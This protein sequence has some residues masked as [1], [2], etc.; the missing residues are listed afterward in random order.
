MPCCVHFLALQLTCCGVVC[1]AHKNN[2]KVNELCL[3]G[4]ASGTRSNAPP[5]NAL[6]R[7]PFQCLV[8][9]L[10]CLRFYQ[11]VCLVLNSTNGLNYNG[12]YTYIMVYIHITSTSQVHPILHHMACIYNVEWQ[13]FQSLFNSLLPPFLTTQ[14]T[15]AFSKL[16][17]KPSPSGYTLYNRS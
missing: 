9:C 2:T 16:P 15:R 6:S 5:S 10:S 3:A 8:S 1:L 12:I 4:K 14:T 11:F 7:T 13:S 17:Q